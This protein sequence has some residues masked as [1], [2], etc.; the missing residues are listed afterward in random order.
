MKS[1]LKVKL[2]KSPK[3]DDEIPQEGFD[4]TMRALAQ[5]LADRHEADILFYNGAISGLA[6]QKVIEMCR[7]RSRR[8]NVILILVTPGGDADAAYR[9]ARCL[10]EKYQK[11]SLFVPGW[12][13]SAGTL[14]AIGADEL[15]MSD[16]GELGPLDV[17]LSVTDELWEYSCNCSTPVVLRGL[18][19]KAFRAKKIAAT[20]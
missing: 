20:G 6:S 11:F 18:S 4:L 2:D 8:S 5:G 14:L 10:Q 13:K 9:I 1:G 12:C 3:I 19:G 16:Y 17:Q 15:Y 7:A